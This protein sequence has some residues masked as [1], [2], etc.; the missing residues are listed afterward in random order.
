MSNNK[1]SGKSTKQ[2]ENEK[3]HENIVSIFTG[4]KT[5]LEKRDVQKSVTIDVLGMKIV[6]TDKKKL[7]ELFDNEI[8]QAKNLVD[9]KPST[10]DR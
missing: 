1:K 5:I 9:G 3:L 4:V 2:I 10:F 8:L 7:F 6:I